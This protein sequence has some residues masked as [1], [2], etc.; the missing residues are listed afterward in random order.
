MDMFKLEVDPEEIICKIKARKPVGVAD[1]VKNFLQNSLFF[2]GDVADMITLILTRDKFI[3]QYRG[4]CAKGWGEE[5][6]R[7]DEFQLADVSSF[8]VETEGNE[9][10]IYFSVKNKNFYFIRENK[11]GNHLGK[12]FEKE[13]NHIR[14]G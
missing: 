14:L 13:L 2:A 5:T 12:E 8:H 6:R 11:E 4:H 3:V 10:H 7:I 1:T 9:E